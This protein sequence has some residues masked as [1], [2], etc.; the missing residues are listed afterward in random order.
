MIGAFHG[1]PGHRERD[2]R[3]DVRPEAR[4]AGQGP[5][6]DQEGARRVLDELRPRRDRVG[7]GGGRPVRAA[8]PGHPG[9]R[10]GPVP[11][12]RGGGPRAGRPRPRARAH[13]VGRALRPWRR[14]PALPGTG[15]RAFA[16]PDRARGRPHGARDRDGA[17]RGG[18]RRARHRGAGGPPR[19]RPAGHRRPVR[20]LDVHGRHG[21]GA[22][23]RRGHGRARAVHHARRGRLR[24]GLSTH[25]ESAHRHRG[26]HRDGVPGRGA[27]REHGV[28]P[29]PP[30]GA[31]PDRGSGIPDLRG[32]PRGG[33][34]PAYARRHP[35]RRG[36][37][38]PA[39]S[40][41]S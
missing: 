22:S 36:T 2:R 32:R 8:H 38:W 39:P 13:G 35:W 26:R 27:R 7:A 18:R 20:A 19:P 41:G 14:R 28:H 16:P 1:R 6:G 4:R 12:A 3:T 30:H 21:P 29:I 40:T 15:G 24:A 10:R 17:P 11:S 23:E 25:H 9:G 31:P 33:C 34:G 37:S 5:P